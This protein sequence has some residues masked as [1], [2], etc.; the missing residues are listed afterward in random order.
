MKNNNSLS[1]E[2]A[3]SIYRTPAHWQTLKIV[4]VVMQFSKN[5][6]CFHYYKKYIRK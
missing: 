6:L 5:I 2:Q 3:D 1:L 4:R